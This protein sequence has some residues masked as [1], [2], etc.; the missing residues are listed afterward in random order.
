MVRAALNVFFSVVAALALA[1]CSTIAPQAKTGAQ[2]IWESAGDVERANRYIV[3]TV[4]NRSTSLN[5][6]AGSSGRD[7]GAI[8]AYGPAP[9]AR[10]EVAALSSQYALRFVDAWPIE[11]LQVHCVVYS[12]LQDANLNEVLERLRR[13]RRV[14]SAQPLQAFN[15]QATASDASTSEPASE[16]YAHLQPHLAQLNVLSA[17]RI[18]RGAGVRVAVIDTGIDERHPDL[19]GRIGAQRNLVGSATAAHAERHGTAVAGVIAA[20]DNNRQGIIGIAPAATVLALRA[21]WPAQSGAARAVCNTFTLAQAL[22]AAIDLHADVVNLSLS[23]PND[24][25]LTRLVAAGQQR[26]MVYVGAIPPGDAPLGFPATVPGVIRVDV[27]HSASAR[28]AALRAPGVDILTLTPAGGYDFL[29][30]SSLSA[31]S[32]SGGVALLIAHNPKLNRESVSDALA[33]SMIVRDNIGATS[34]DLCV[35]LMLV[36][37]AVNCAHE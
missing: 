37:K 22:S 13:D 21:C 30:G 14:E 19:K 12:V 24:P 2:S 17:H 31:A 33:Q 10:A 36:D 5:L 34:V 1:A 20:L 23:G 6:R 7:Y 28:D 4:R 29:S 16:P 3:V 8:G 18:T 27:T 26:G 32:I 15:T 9:R 35:A 11:I 25:L